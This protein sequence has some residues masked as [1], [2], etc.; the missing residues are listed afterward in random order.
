MEACQINELMGD[1]KCKNELSE[2]NAAANTSVSNIDR[3]EERETDQLRLKLRQ[4]KQRLQ[5]KLA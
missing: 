1:L 2:E 4:C 5:L 3:T